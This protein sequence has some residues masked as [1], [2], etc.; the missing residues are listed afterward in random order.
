[1]AS[2]PP[3]DQSPVPPVL[4]HTVFLLGVTFGDDPVLNQQE[5]QML[6]RAIHSL[7]SALDP[8]RIIYLLQAEVLL[9]YYLFHKGR[10]LEGAYHTAAAVSIAVACKLHKLRSA[11]WPAAAADADRGVNLPPPRDA[12]EEGDRILAFWNVLVL[13]RCW[14]AWSQSLSVLIQE[15]SVTMQIDTPW[16]LKTSSYEQVGAVLLAT[17]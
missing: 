8:S 3:T 9:A 15:A 11:S 7:T 2:I 1:M 17:Q 5:S 10:N 14:S 4:V 16:P 13:D 6:T 12:I